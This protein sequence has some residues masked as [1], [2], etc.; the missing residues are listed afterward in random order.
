MS[1]DQL[2]PVPADDEPSGPVISTSQ[3]PWTAIPRFVPG[4]T[5]VQEYVKKMEFLAAMWPVEHLDLLAP[6]AA[7]MVEGSAFAS[8]SKLDASK[9]KVKSL[10]GVK[11]LV[12]AIGGSWGATDFEERFEFFE[13]AL[14][15]ILQK[16]DESNDSYVS[17]AEAVFSELLARGTTLQEVQAYVLLRQSQLPSE[18]KKRILLENPK[19][20]YPAV[21]KALRLLGSKFFHEV[22]SGKTNNRTKVYDT[23]LTEEKETSESSFL[24]TSQSV[25]VAD[26]EDIPTDM[27]E[28]LAAQ[29]D[30]DA[31]L[32]Q[33]FEA[34]FE[35]FAQ[36][37][38]ELH[39]AMVNYVEARQRLQ[40][41]RKTRGFWPANAKSKG[42][43]KSHGKQYGKSQGRRD[44]LSKIA[45]SQCKICLQMGHWK[46]ECPQRGKDGGNSNPGAST[47]TPPP[48]AATNVAETAEILGNQPNNDLEIFTEDDLKTTEPQV[49]CS[50]CVQDCLMLI[51][52]PWNNHDNQ[53]KLSQ[54]FMKFKKHVH[55]FMNR[56]SKP[57]GRAE[58]SPK[59]VQQPCTSMITQQVPF[60]TPTCEFVPDLP[61]LQ[62]NAEQEGQAI[63]DTGASR[64]I[65]GMKPL[66]SLL[67]RL[68]S[69]VRS[70]VQRKASQVRFRF[71]N[72]Q[73]LTSQ[74]RVMLPLK[75]KSNEKLWLGVE[76]VEG[77]TPFLFSKRAF[78]Q[79]GGILDTTKDQCTLSRLQKTIELTT[80]ATGLYL[81]DMVDFCH[82][83]EA[84]NDSHD[85]T[86]S[87]V[88][89]ACHVGDNT[90]CTGHTKFVHSRSF[91]K[92]FPPKP[93]SANQPPVILPRPDLAETRHVQPRS[94]SQHAEGDG[95]HHHGH[96]D[97]GSSS[98]DEHDRGSSQ[99][100]TGRGADAP[101]DEPAPNDVPG[102]ASSK[103]PSPTPCRGPREETRKF[104]TAYDVDEHSGDKSWRPTAHV[105]AS[106]PERRGRSGQLLSGLLSEAQDCSPG[107]EES[108]EGAKCSSIQPSCTIQHRESVPGADPPR[109][110]ASSSDLG[111]ME[112]KEGDLGSQASRQ[113]LHGC[114]DQRH[115]LLRVESVPIPVTASQPARLC[116]L[117]PCATGSRC[118]PRSS[119]DPECPQTCMSLDVHLAA[120]IQS[121]QLECSK[122]SPHHVEQQ[123]NQSIQS[124]L[125]KMQNIA[126]DVFLTAPKHTPVR[127]KLVILEVYAG[128]SSPLTDCL[129]QL[130]ARAYRFTRKH[131][132]L[133][134]FAGQQALWR[135]IDEINP[136][137][138]FVAPECGPWGGW[139]RLNAQKSI[140]LWDHVHARQDHERIHIRLC[141]R[142][143]KYQINRNKHFHLEQPI[144]STM[145]QTDEFRPITQLS[146]RVCFDMCYFGLKIPNTN[147]YLRKRSQ[148]WSTS[149][150]VIQCLMKNDCPANHEH[151]QIAGSMHHEGRNVRISEFCATYCHGFAQTFAEILMKNHTQNMTHDIL[152]HE[153]E[154]EHPSK[155]RRFAPNAFKKA[156]VDD[157]SSR[158]P[159]R[160]SKVPEAATGT[161]LPEDS[162]WYEAFRVAHR[163]APRV[164]NRKC[165]TE[166]DLCE[167]V[168]QLVNED[169]Q[170]TCVF[171][172]R[173]T[174]RLQVPLSAPTSQEAPWRH[175]LC[176]HRSSGIVHDL[177]PQQW[178]G[179]TRAARIAK[180]CPSR[181]TITI[182]GNKTTEPISNG[183]MNAPAAGGEIVDS[184]DQA[185]GPLPVL[186]PNQQC[187][188]WAPPPTPLHGPDFRALQPDEK[189]QLIKLHKNLGHPD[190]KTLSAHLKVQGAA[191]HI[192]RAASDYVCDACVETQKPHHQ[193]PAKLHSPKEFNDLV[194]ID[195][196]FWRGKKGF[197]CYVI[198]IY[199]EASG[200]HL[201][202]RL[203]GRNL[204]H[205]IPAFQS[206]WT[207]WAGFPR[208]VYLDP[209]GEF[210]ADQWLDFLQ[211]QNAHVHVTAAAWQRG[212]IER[213]GSILK[214]MLHRLD[215][216]QKFE[217][218]AQFDEMLMMCCQSKNALAKQHGYTPEQIVLGK[219]THLPASLTSDETAAAHSL[220]LGEDLECD[221]FRALLDRRTKARQAFILADNADAIRR[222]SLRQSRPQRGPYSPGQLVL[223]WT[224]RSIPNRGESG[225][226]YGPARVIIQEG[227]SIVWLSHGTRL[228]R[229]APECIRPAS[230]REWN[231]WQEMLPQMLDDQA[232]HPIPMQSQ[233]LLQPPHSLPETPVPDIE[234]SPSLLET[235]NNEPE[236]PEQEAPHPST[237]DSGETTPV[238][239]S[240]L[241]ELENPEDETNDDSLLL[242]MANL[243]ET[244]S[245][246]P[247]ET[248]LHVFDAF[249]PASHESRQA[250]VCLAEDGMPFIDQP[251][252]C[253]VEECYMLEIPLKPEDL[254]A[255]S[256]ENNPAE[257]A[258][259]AAAGQRARV[260]VQVKHL[261]PKEKELFDVAK[262]NELS[263]WIA[264]NAL[265]PVL[266][267]SLNPDQ[268]LK[269]RWVLTWKSVEA[270]G[271]KPAHQKAKARLVVLGYQDPKLTEVARDSPTLTK[272]GRSTILQYLASQ[273]WE[274][275]SF[276]IKTA[277]L[278][279]KA[280][281]RNP[282]AMEPPCE[283]RR[284]MKLS[285]EEVCSL[286]GN[287]YGRVDAP[288]LFYKELSSQLK[289]LNF[290]I[291]PLEPCMFM[292]ESGHGDQRKL[293]GVL[294]VH[295]DDGIGG[296]DAYFHQQLQKLSKT[297]PFGSFKTRKFTFT[298]IQLEQLQDF[299][300]RA[301]QSD[302]VH[303]ILAID[304]GRSRREQPDELATENEKS[305]LR[306]LV[307]SL[308]YA[309]T[310][311]RPDIAAKLGEVQVDM[312]KPTIK[313][314][315]QRNRVLREAQEHSHV[316]ICFRS[317]PVKDV[318]HVSFGDAS[319][320]SPKQLS[321]FQGSL[322]CAT[323]TELNNNHEA[324][325]SPLTW[326][327]KKISRVVRSTLS[328]EAYSMSRSVDRLGWLRLLWGT[329]TIPEF[330]WQNPAKAYASLPLGIITTDCRSLYDLVSRTAMPQCE[331]YRTTL[332][333]LL[334]REQCKDHC[335]FRWIPTTIML[336]DAL[337]KNM[338]PSLLRTALQR[339]LFCLFDEESVLRSNANRK[340]AVSWLNDKAQG[341]A[342][343]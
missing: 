97:P 318:T 60:R 251:L 161:P 171:I 19:L 118:Q 279:G 157:G 166:S 174:D 260:E 151:A 196:F 258:H 291:H 282:L 48:A 338:D 9:L 336:A 229:R 121:C 70:T 232:Q 231:A 57:S 180:T 278:R 175:T 32:V 238:A 307:G 83:H 270:E 144:G 212:R 341:T 281:E 34:E 332:E 325:I 235:P 182:F 245:E 149:P 277:F 236:Q 203:D 239:D 284:K 209:A 184:R 213:H 308:Q 202:K 205:A 290:K 28:A 135:L 288:L 267:K 265:R 185:D 59:P 126:D 11:T 206:L 244:T 262:D 177:G 51:H 194:G 243:T 108:G 242:Q 13:K 160:A 305:K 154:E 137:H 297:L 16:S 3:L 27:V 61:I 339:G 306:A 274:L 10:D 214:D 75:G 173:G 106:Q 113:H 136:D 102:N 225:R 228:I 252:D 200:F 99:R 105:H 263:C 268:I 181:L 169:F 125:T 58:T 186:N 300:I 81:I 316:H 101:I 261:T 272:E 110:D 38:P 327:S 289:Q 93:S 145:T 35:E 4:T 249:I 294:G 311:T 264:T 25:L 84:A 69:S 343:Q 219:A 329:L 29:D 328:A 168:Q 215:V 189:Q 188:G 322:I 109:G 123:Y 283:L 223:Y 148:I 15:G 303:R 248:A 179:L 131:G 296:G 218:N 66:A 55:G 82:H 287:A 92:S 266:R 128:E 314:L 39:Q 190:P 153:D 275:S 240:D 85:H 167:L 312:S 122:F 207:F 216:D 111:R 1:G 56:H 222:A 204:D 340:L 320:A 142:L 18:D 65:I 165:D 271:D 141:A 89:S 76:V 86:E 299:S 45:R 77:M 112:P 6:R 53:L 220:A 21:V 269:S 156:R 163:M 317:I 107:V 17:R 199:D 335:V 319:F 304:V 33:Q 91:T 132:D 230:L 259:V 24:A 301:S 226:W 187:E 333:V 114:A 310:H 44:L 201:A 62:A 88:G 90:S 138:I 147:K 172:C 5:N 241:P 285:D 326:S 193:R 162:L 234:Y 95:Q 22:Q 208:A 152:V 49:P 87:F 37:T 293:H 170:V 176:M 127:R 330:Q 164:G 192:V 321:S 309:V 129:K 211:A 100:S 195:G 119:T 47:A 130:G 210:R 302:Y 224:K 134:T 40:D 221:R 246:H 2:P 67:Q 253:S 42:K 315:L 198:H 7:L 334:I 331:E 14:Y 43:G 191:E 98:V 120:M 233:Q 117:L 71:G 183:P 72:N 52:H 104:R 36:E 298:G 250:T 227:N 124:S 64:C 94:S 54:R 79:L 23:L 68:P 26:D 139:N 286:V 133:S 143:C 280:D 247:E 140:A 237:V 74:Y 20:E 31:L 254:L 256:Q 276:D 337:T 41:R 30:P 197:Q 8:I 116:G 313:T 292:L 12:R 103:S 150:V 342:M 257:M 255:W 46:A 155:R 50:S 273:R 63:L 324:P 96:I 80:N 73:T 158:V 323:T 178:H 295:V 217:T 146:Q 78:K 115:G 159:V